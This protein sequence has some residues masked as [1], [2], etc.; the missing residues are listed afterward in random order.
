MIDKFYRFRPVKRLLG[1]DGELSNQEIY[2]AHPKQF[3]DPMEGYKDILWSGDK[4]IWKNLFRHY[5]Y[6]LLNLATLTIISEEEYHV[7]VDDMRVLGSIEDFPTEQMKEVFATMLGSFFRSNS[8]QTLITKISERKTPVRKDELELYLSSIHLFALKNVID[9][10]IDEGLYPES[11]RVMPEVEDSI[12]NVI[13]DEF[14]SGIESVANNKDDGENQLSLLFFIQNNASKQ[15]KLITKYNSRAQSGQSNKKNFLLLDF[16]SLYIK[17]LEKVCFPEWYTACFISECKNSSVWG[18]YGDNH[19]GAC[20]VFKPIAE[21]KKYYLELKGING[22]SSTK[23]KLYGWFNLELKK[24]DYISGQGQI[25]FFRSLGS[26]SYPTM[27]TMWY[28]SEN[29]ERSIC[30][31]NISNSE[32][33]WREYYWENFYR[34]VTKKSKDWAYENEYRAIL[35]SSITDFSNNSDRL[36]KYHFSS[37]EGIIFGIK[38]SDEDKIEIINTIERKCKENQRMDFKFYQAYFCFEEN[39]IKTSELSLLKFNND[40]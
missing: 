38:M 30:A 35:S 36:L 12:R 16:P 26:L 8:I 21:D 9:L 3:N 40:V 28:N 5:L 15:L 22:W 31:E 19:A 25:D 17:S 39:Y 20:L 33:E 10:L 2:F 34:D 7:T 23:G 11:Q 32:Q 6:C 1:D 18:H 13:S 24:I 27:N 37:L 14:F 4:I 29:G